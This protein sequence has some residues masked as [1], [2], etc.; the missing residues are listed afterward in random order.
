[1]KTGKKAFSLIEAVTVI[2]VLSVLAAIVIPTLTGVKER[3]QEESIKPALTLVALEVRKISPSVIP[4]YP[5]TGV[6]LE[7]LTVTQD[8]SQT[9][10]DISVAKV[11]TNQ[12]LL[13]AYTNGKCVILLHSINGNEK[14]AESEGN[15]RASNYIMNVGSITGS[16]QSPTVL[17]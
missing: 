1:M 10:T 2:I 13:S 9:H 4:D 16:A 6:E 12:M 8:E 3:S 17:L 7:G 11:D 15:C 5:E 14:W